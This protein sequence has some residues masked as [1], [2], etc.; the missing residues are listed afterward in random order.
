MTLV[1]HELVES[2]GRSDM[3]PFRIGVAQNDNPPKNGS[4][5][6]NLSRRYVYTYIDHIDGSEWI[7]QDNTCWLQYIDPKHD[8]PFVPLFGP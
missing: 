5:G 7:T 3:G 2:Q 4:T 1:K 6:L 8:Q